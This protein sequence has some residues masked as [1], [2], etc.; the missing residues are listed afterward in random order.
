MRQNNRGIGKKCK[1]KNYFNKT[2]RKVFSYMACIAFGAA[3][4]IE[5]K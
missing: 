1:T 3:R 2:I 4:G 5:E